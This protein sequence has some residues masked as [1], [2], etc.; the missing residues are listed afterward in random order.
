MEIGQK[1]WKLVRTDGQ[2][3]QT[4]RQTDRQIGRFLYNPQTMFAGTIT[5]RGQPTRS[6]GVIL[7]E[8]QGLRKQILEEDYPKSITADR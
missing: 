1:M 5:R 6:I 2:D 7:N 3:G 4:D 8:G